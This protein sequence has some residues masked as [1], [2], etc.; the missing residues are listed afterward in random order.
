MIGYGAEDEH[1]VAELTYNY[2]IRTYEPGNIHLASLI[3]SDEVFE[4]ASKIDGSTK[5]ES[6]VTLTSPCGYNFEVTKGNQGQA[7]CGVRLA[8]SDLA[9]TK[10]FWCGLAKLTASEDQDKLTLNY[11]DRQ[12]WMEFEKVDEIK[13]AGNYGRTAIAWPT[14]GLRQIEAEVFR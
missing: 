4:M 5:T 12:I 11:P 14:D 10:A 7:V 1:F 3:K 6:K 8:S 13:P 9:R 2:E